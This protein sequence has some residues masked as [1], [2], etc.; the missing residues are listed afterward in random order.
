MTDKR[1]IEVFSA[2]CALCEDTI[3]LV[4]KIACDSCEV[5]IHNMNE[6][7]VAR[8]AKEYGVRSVPAV[9]I[10]GKL[11]NC[12]SGR[13]PSEQVLRLEGIGTSLT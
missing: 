4:Q 1:T 2:G 10:N 12:C 5:T 6:P 9:V 11:A 13:G 3:A 8:K 7:A